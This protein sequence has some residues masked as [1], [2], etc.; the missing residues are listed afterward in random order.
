MDG[1]VIER[2]DATRQLR[3]LDVR[4]IHGFNFTVCQPGHQLPS[5]DKIVTQCLH[6]SL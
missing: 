1:L 6:G 2:F 4:Q 3:R 5:D